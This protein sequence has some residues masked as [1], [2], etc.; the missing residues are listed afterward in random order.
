M[1][2]YS[3]HIYLNR[4]QFIVSLNIFLLALFCSPSLAMEEPWSV[5]SHSPVFDSS[6]KGLNK[7]SASH[8]NALIWAVDGFQAFISPVDG[9]RCSMYPT[10]S[11]YSKEAIKKYGSVKGFIMTSDR[12]LHEADEPSYAPL[13]N[14]HGELRVYDPVKNNDFW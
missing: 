3:F 4:L 10:C 14:I 6:S 11:S 13:I 5:S 8:F 1:K 9:D 2:N 7:E 12:L